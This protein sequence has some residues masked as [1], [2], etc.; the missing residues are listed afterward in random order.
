MEVVASDDPMI[1][2]ARLREELGADVTVRTADTGD[3]DAAIA[4]AQD[5]DA[6]VVDVSTPVTATVLAACSDL[7]IVARAGVGVDNVDVAA[8]AERGIEV[9]NVPDY[10]TD[11]VATHTVSLLLACARRL[12]VYDRDVKA[13]EWDWTAAG[14]IHRLRG[15][16]LGFVSFGPIARRVREQTGGFDLTCVAHDPYVDG[17]EMD[18]AGVEK[19]DFEALL[20]RADLVSVTAPL[21]DE[22]RGMVDAAAFERLGDHAVVV[23]TGRGGVVDEAALADALERG[24][25]AAAGLDVFA[26]EPPGDSPLF[27]RDGRRERS[28][29][30]LGRGPA[31]P[32]RPRPRLGVSGDES[33]PR[34][35]VSGDESRR[36]S[37]PFARRFLRFSPRPR[38]PARVATTPT[39]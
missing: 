23:N 19:V 14:G 8:A 28:C 31:R 24:E 9:S 15:S 36:S 26:E 33:R 22:T 17:E 21:T 29:G 35:G 6:L 11:E 7:R 25:V 38:S 39:G 37:R 1:D 4:A 18:A 32:D 3:E 12:G 27:D 20:D 34:Q 30:P 13:G 16:T 10:C 2:A 5:A